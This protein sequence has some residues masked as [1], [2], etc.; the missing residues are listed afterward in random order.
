[1]SIEDRRYIKDCLKF[2]DE[3]E[4]KGLFWGTLSG[5]VALFFPGIRRLAFY[6]RLPFAFGLCYFWAKIG[7][8]YGRDVLLVKTRNVIENWERDMGIRHFQ[9]SI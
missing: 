1:M 2:V 6:K 3:Y 7:Y 9:L 4:N 8:N 5:V